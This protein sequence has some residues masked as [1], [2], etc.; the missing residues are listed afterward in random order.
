MRN[1]F[2]AFIYH[3]IEIYLSYSNLKSLFYRHNVAVAKVLSFH[4][5]EL[6]FC[7]LPIYLGWHASLSL[8]L[9]MWQSWYQRMLR[10]QILLVFMFTCLSRSHSLLITHI[11]RNILWILPKPSYVGVHLRKFFDIKDRL[12]QF[13]FILH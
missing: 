5:L 13:F 11:E 1:S 10:N 9:P 6:H 2:V 3:I 4:L 7:N 12:N 8:T